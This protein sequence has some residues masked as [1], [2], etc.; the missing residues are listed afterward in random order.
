M[1]R[2]VRRRV[3]G[4]GVFTIVDGPE[5]DPAPILLLH[6]FPSSSRDFAF[7]GPRLAEEHRVVAH[8][9][10]GFGMSDKPADY[11]YSLLEQA[12]VALEVW[13]SLGVRAGHLVAHDYGTSIATELLARR[14]HGLCPVDLRS[15]TFCNGSV[16]IEMSQLTTGQRI[17]RRPHL[18]PIFARLANKRTFQRQLRGI[19]GDAR[20]VPESE[21]DAMWEGLIRDHGRERLPALIGYVSERWRFKSRW[22]DPLRRLDI[23]CHIL[24]GTQDPVAVR[25][26]AEKLANEIPGAEVTWL[27]GVGHYPMLE[28]PGRWA[29]AALRFIEACASRPAS[30]AIVSSPP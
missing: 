24:W 12:E 14:E 2:G 10:V 15:V 9:H 8:D 23:P 13:R 5:D 28:T 1:A 3:F 17:L 19:L 26:I 20:S 4:R 16:H 25:G 30:A 6:G 22:I 27:E 21:L 29:S 11:S 18:G 7:A